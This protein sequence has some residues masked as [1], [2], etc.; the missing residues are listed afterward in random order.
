MC[1]R[2]TGFLT[3]ETGK[4]GKTR[5]FQHYS[6][7][8]AGKSGKLLLSLGGKGSTRRRAF[9]SAPGFRLSAFELRFATPDDLC[10]RDRQSITQIN[11]AQPLGKC[12]FHGLVKSVCV[13]PPEA[14]VM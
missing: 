4:A 2:Y 10:F 8:V 13:F 6:R 9:H 14:A 7:T 1:R 5:F 3:D 11:R 12:G